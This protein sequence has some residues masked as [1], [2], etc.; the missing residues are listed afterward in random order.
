MLSEIR[1]RGTLLVQD[2]ARSADV[3]SAAD[4]D[5]R[6]GG[7]VCAGIDDDH[8]SVAFDVHLVASVVRQTA[9]EP[10][11]LE[12]LTVEVVVDELVSVMYAGD[13]AR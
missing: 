6:Q 12:T 8:P 4:A 13:A 2:D 11:H 1:S 3:N 5:S 7:C 10:R 9:D